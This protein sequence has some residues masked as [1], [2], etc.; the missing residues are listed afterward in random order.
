MREKTLKR[1]KRYMFIDW[2]ITVALFV[3]FAAYL[4]GRIPFVNVDEVLHLIIESGL[5]FGLSI[6]CWRELLIWMMERDERVGES[7]RQA[8]N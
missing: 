2:A 6:A 4:V 1:T 3:I 8:H 7:K 5:V